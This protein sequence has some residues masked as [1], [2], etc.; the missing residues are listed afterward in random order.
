MH[1]QLELVLKDS[2]RI[3]YF[4]TE[5]EAKEFLNKCK[6][7]VSDYKIQPLEEKK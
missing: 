5:E 1:Y 2:I 7:T 4:D 6:E 3:L